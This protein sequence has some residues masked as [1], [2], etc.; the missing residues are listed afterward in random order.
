VQRL[1]IP[2]TVGNFGWDEGIAIAG[3]KGLV[4]HGARPWRI[5]QQN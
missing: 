5:V 2:G 1:G 4:V 3:K